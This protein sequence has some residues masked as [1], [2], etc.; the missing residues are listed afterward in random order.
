MC[1][2]PVFCRLWWPV[3]PLCESYPAPKWWM[4]CAKVRLGLAPGPFPQDGR[5]GQVSHLLVAQTLT[6]DVAL[7]VVGEWRWAVPRSGRSSRR[8]PVPEPHI[9]S[10]WKRSSL[11]GGAWSGAAGGGCEGLA[12]VFSAWTSG[13]GGRKR[14]NVGCRKTIGFSICFSWGHVR[15]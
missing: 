2:L 3:L 9:S 13:L 1:F 5:P 11:V 6:L 8:F 14:C 12:S 10:A 4:E 15:A 7:P